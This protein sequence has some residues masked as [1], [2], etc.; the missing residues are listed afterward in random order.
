MT[1]VHNERNINNK[2]HTRILYVQLIIFSVR[3]VFIMWC[4]FVFN[5]TC[6]VQQTFVAIMLI[7]TLYAMN[8]STTSLIH[9][10]FSALGIQNEAKM[11]L[12]NRTLKH[13]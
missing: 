1:D 7:V 12:K 9:S 2:T 3:S 6:T 5:S 10:V 4:C 8:F 11:T 13:W